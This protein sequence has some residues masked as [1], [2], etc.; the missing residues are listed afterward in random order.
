MLNEAGERKGNYP[1]YF[2]VLLIEDRWKCCE[3]LLPNC[4]GFE[5]TETLCNPPKLEPFVF[6]LQF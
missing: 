2:V 5:L 1:L 4:S 6:I 3:G